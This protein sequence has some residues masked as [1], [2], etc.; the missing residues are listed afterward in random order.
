MRKL[1]VFGKER[2]LNE[3]DYLIVKDSEKVV[4]KNHLLRAIAKSEE[5]AEPEA[6]LIPQG[7]DPSRG[8]FLVKATVKLTNGD[9]FEDWGESNPKNLKNDIARENP[10]NMARNRAVSRV[11]LRALGLSGQV[12][13]EDEI[14]RSETTKDKKSNAKPKSEK[15]ATP[16]K[17]NDIPKETKRASSSKKIT[18]EVKE[19]AGQVIMHFGATK[20]VKVA[21]FT[22]STIDYI[23]NKMSP[24]DDKAKKL[25]L[26]TKIYHQG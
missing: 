2:E 26:A 16:I 23:L 6:E 4:L 17:D 3:E 7:C 9:V 12:L 21:D 14:D 25:A 20:G 8:I 11:L 5:I 24:K 13:S 18:P 15:P 10:A 19:K 22:E 1:T